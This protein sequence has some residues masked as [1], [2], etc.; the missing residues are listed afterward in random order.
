[1]V[2]G[3]CNE[4]KVISPKLHELTDPLNKQ[5]SLVDGNATN[6]TLERVNEWRRVV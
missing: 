5:Y 1:M 6:T 4:K 3:A 2:I